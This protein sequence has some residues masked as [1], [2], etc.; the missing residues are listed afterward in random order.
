MRIQLMTDGGADI[1]QQLIEQLQLEIV[2]LYLNFSDGEYKTGTTLKLADFHQKVKE[3]NEVP[4]SAAPSPNDFYEAYKKVP[5]DKPIIMLS[6]SKELSST[7][8]NAV[9]AKNMILEA[10][11][12]R[13]IAVINTK[14]ASGGIA[15]LL[16]DL[17]GKIQAGDTFE[18]VVQHT[19]DRVGDTVTLFVLQT[20]DNLVRGGRISK[21][22]GK[23]AKT[24]SIKLLMR[25]SE[26]GEIEV[27]ERVRG[28][29]RA[30]KRFIQQ[31]GEYT[32]SAENKSLFMTHCNSESRA[33]K[34][35]ND[36]K[37]KYSFKETFL[38]DIGP[39]IAT[40]GGDG[41]IVI[42]FFQDR[43]K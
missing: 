26:Q 40:H 6:L 8:Q 12:E 25:G 10:E 24:L 15:L 9:A 34:L 7:Y 29:K 33:I 3:L 39:I 28:E 38:T 13:R 11:P 16:H 22:T 30:L 18:Q 35:L 32:K 27:T 20:L 21:V 5:Q 37:D 17:Y 4:R 19:K 42:A 23:I 43:N 2:P 31:I 36:I 41:A 14:T 1:P